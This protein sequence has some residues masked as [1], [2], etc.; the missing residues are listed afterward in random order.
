MKYGHL[1]SKEM[2][3]IPWDILLVDIIG[4]IKLEDKVRM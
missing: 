2:E 4:H 1:T 3:D